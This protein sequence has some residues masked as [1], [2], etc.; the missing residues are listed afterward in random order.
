[1]INFNDKNLTVI[2]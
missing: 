1:M 2:Q